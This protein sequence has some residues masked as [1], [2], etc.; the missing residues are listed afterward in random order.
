MCREITSCVL[1][2]GVYKWAENQ[3][4]AST[5]SIILFPFIRSEFTTKKAC[6]GTGNEKMFSI[7]LK[8]KS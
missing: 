5:I 4:I 8:K 1:G 6:S 2:F 7:F 3:K